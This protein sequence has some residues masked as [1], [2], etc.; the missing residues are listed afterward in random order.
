MARKD[1]GADLARAF[2]AQLQN[3][4]ELGAIFAELLEPVAERSDER[5]QRIGK[6]RLERS[7]A[8][9]GET[10]EH[11]F[12][13]L[14]NNRAV[15]SDKVLRF[16]TAVEIGGIARKRLGIGLRLADLLGD[17]RRRCR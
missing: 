10:A 8:L 13:A 4:V 16:G 2:G 14:A 12:N 9:P 6:R 3:P 11:L 15:N 5:D 1:R 17:H 7:E